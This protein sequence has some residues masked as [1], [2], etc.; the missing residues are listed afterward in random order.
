MVPQ[1]S[2]PMVVHRDGMENSVTM[3]VRLQ[4]VCSV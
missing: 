4:T 1:G 3:N 2:V